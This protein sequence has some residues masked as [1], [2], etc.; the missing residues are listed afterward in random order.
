M[1]IVNIEKPETITISYRQEHGDSDYGSCLWARFN[2][3]LKNYNLSIESD[4][5][6]YAYGWC[7]TPNSETFLHLCSRFEAG[8]ILEKIASRNV[9][10]GGATHKSLIEWLEEYDGYGWELLS[11]SQRQEIEDACHSNRNDFAVLRAIQEALEDTEFEG[12]CSEYDIACCIEMDYPNG[13]KKIVDVFR[14]HIQPVVKKIAEE[15]P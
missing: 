9:V 11:E 8:Y 6:S 7:P 3:D 15:T 13:A 2:F 10:N 1:P 5:G 4:C 12:S 14:D